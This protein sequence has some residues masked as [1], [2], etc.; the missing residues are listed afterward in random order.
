[1]D[2]KRFRT[3]ALYSCGVVICVSVFAFLLFKHEWTRGVIDN[4][5]AVFSPVIYG[6]VIAYICNPVYMLLYNKLFAFF[7]TKKKERPKLK[8]VFSLIFTYVFVFLCISLVI[9][10][11]IPQ[12][13]TSYNDLVKNLPVYADSVSDTIENIQSSPLSKTIF[14]HISYD[15]LNEIANEFLN[16]SSELLK[17]ISPQILSAFNNVINQLKNFFFGLIIS[18]YLLA[19]K[20][21]I[22][23]HC[24]KTLLAFVS[25][26]KYNKI[27]DF[28][29]LTDK[30]FGGFL[31]GKIMECVTVGFVFAV[32]F[33]ILR[34]PYF[35]LIA[36]T[37]GVMNI[38]P[39]VGMIFGGVFGGL[40]VL[41]AD[42]SKVLWYIIAVVIIFIL[43]NNILAPHILSDMTGTTA[44]G[45]IVAVLV[46]GGIFGIGGMIFGVPLYALIMQVINGIVERRLRKKQCSTELDDYLDD[47]GK[48]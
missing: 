10:L 11:L 1:M 35:Q 39:T 18:V 41:I 34:I 9:R 6:I 47:G 5:A 46:M 3:I 13:I 29:R 16:D 17:N 26:K 19:S 40:I 30:T 2:K 31:L 8:K 7:D 27:K 25:R 4:I 23:A 14:E 37:L 28:I 45:V 44:L 43:D 38:V 48:K 36:I 24:K 20:D 21:R 42:P 32:I 33:G 22:F 15:K 12:I